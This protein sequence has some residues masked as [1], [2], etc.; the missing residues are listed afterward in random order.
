MR[1]FHGQVV[2]TNQFVIHEQT[3]IHIII[4][5][6]IMISWIVKITNWGTTCPMRVLMITITASIWAQ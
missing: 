2:H 5:I 4:Q 6:L 3:Y 1:T